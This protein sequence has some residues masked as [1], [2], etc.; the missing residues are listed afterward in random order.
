MFRLSK[1][2][3]LQVLHES[4]GNS[5]TINKYGLCTVWCEWWGGYEI[6][7]VSWRPGGGYVQGINAVMYI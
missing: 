7:C 1:N 5:Y 3:H 4:L 2:S 6:P